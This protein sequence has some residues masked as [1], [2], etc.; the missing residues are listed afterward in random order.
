MQIHMIPKFKGMAIL[1]DRSL[2]HD[3]MEKIEM[4]PAD[5]EAYWRMIDTTA[6]ELK[7]EPENY[8][9]EFL[10][11]PLAARVSGYFSSGNLRGMELAKKP[12]QVLKGEI[13][14]DLDYQKDGDPQETPLD[15]GQRIRDAIAGV[16]ESVESL[17]AFVKKPD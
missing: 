3:A 17:V 13:V 9:V 2:I 7:R 6:D 16:K 4:P 15:F 12:G 10:S 14:H 5:R 11:F 8:R 1:R